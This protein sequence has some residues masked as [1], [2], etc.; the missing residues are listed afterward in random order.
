MT[1]RTASIS[2]DISG[3]SLFQTA[4]TNS[5]GTI[6]SFTSGENEIR[7]YLKNDKLSVVY[8]KIPAELFLSLDY[9][10]K[11]VYSSL[12]ALTWT[13]KTQSGAPGTIPSQKPFK[14]N[15]YWYIVGSTG[16][17]YRSEMGDTWTLV[18]SRS[19]SVSSGVLFCSN[20][21]TIVHSIVGSPKFF[22]S[23]DGVNWTTS[24]YT[25]EGI[26]SIFFYG[27]TFC[28]FDTYNSLHGITTFNDISSATSSSNWYYSE[29]SAYTSF[30][31]AYVDGSDIY[32]TDYTYGSSNTTIKKITALPTGH[33][34]YASTTTLANSYNEWTPDALV[35]GN[36]LCL[37]YSYSNILNTAVGGTN[38]PHFIFFIDAFFNKKDN[39]FYANVL[40]SYVFKYYMYS[41]PD[42]VNWT[43]V[44]SSLSGI[45]LTRYCRVGEPR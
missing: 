11:K 21:T 1:W 31:Y 16:S 17:I 6:T 41:S 45:N 35:F 10:S 29:S 34:W 20:S 42:L 40:D 9:D 14:W 12:N 36:G 4:F 15:G 44:T 5:S 13:E 38:P 22:Y 19:S 39:K 43:D 33:N 24:T 3:S 2:A 7:K 32:F 8:K 25:S 27:T 26:G 37:T 23:T 30:L 28:L 18:F